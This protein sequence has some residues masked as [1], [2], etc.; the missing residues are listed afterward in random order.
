MIWV[1]MLKRKPKESGEYY[2]RGRFGSGGYTYYNS[3]KRNFEFNFEVDIKYLFWLDERGITYEQ[4]DSVI[5]AT[6]NK[7]RND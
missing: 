2:W 5:P 4:V 6:L 7:S 1:S 3:E